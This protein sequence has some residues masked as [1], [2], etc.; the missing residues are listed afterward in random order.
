MRARQTKV[1]DK[2]RQY[3][4]RDRS[5]AHR[6]RAGARGD[7]HMHTAHTLSR[8]PHREVFAESYGSPRHVSRHPK[9]YDQRGRIRR[10]GPLQRVEVQRRHRHLVQR[11]G[12]VFRGF[13]YFCNN[14]TTHTCTTWGSVGF[15]KLYG[16]NEL[17]TS[18]FSHQ[19][20]S[21]GCLGHLIS[22]SQ[23][24]LTIGSAGMYHISWALR[25][26]VGVC[27]SAPRQAIAAPRSA[28]HD[29]ARPL[30]VTAGP[31]G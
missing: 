20:P 2:V 8:P 15:R 5:R 27:G 26:R 12:V 10:L 29:L 22:T 1:K 21:G 28:F 14:G 7:E 11:G 18:W 17:D 6:S 9:R 31:N 3:L 4:S 19:I 25:A 30:L 16:P 13:N 24:N 23:P